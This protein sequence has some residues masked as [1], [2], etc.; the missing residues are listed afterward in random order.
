MAMLSGL[1]LRKGNLQ[2]IYHGGKINR[3][4]IQIV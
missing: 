1:F 2:F 3:K 4:R